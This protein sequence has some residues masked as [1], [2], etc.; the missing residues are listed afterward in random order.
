MLVSVATVS[1]ALAVT[2]D[3]D[4]ILPVLVEASLYLSNSYPVMGLAN[5]VDESLLTAVPNLTYLS[6]YLPE[7]H[8]S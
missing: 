5:S 8:G 1:L 4:F 7:V 6:T 2:L 3:L